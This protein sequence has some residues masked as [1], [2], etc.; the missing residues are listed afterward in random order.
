M[1][2][3]LSAFTIFL[4]TAI[5]Y[6]Q[7]YSYQA[8]NTQ[9]VRK[10][11]GVIASD[12]EGNTII[13]GYFATSITFGSFTLTNNNGY[14]QAFVAKKLPDG[15]FAWAKMFTPLAITGG[16]SFS[17][18]HGVCTDATGNVYVTGRFSG[19]ISFGGNISLSSTKNGTTY[20]G[21]IFTL[22]MSPAGTVLWAKSVG[23]AN[24]GC[25]AGE[26]GNSVA[27]DNSGNVYATGQIVFKVFKNT[28][29]C[30][31]IVQ[32]GPS[33]TNATSK[34]ITCPY[35]VKYNAA[36]TK[37]WEKKYGNNGALAGTSCW[38]NHPRG[39]D[40]GTDGSNIYVTGYFYGNVDFGN[41]FLNTGS[42]TVSNTFLI[43]LNESGSSIWSRSVTGS[44]NSTYG[45][46]GLG[47][48]LFV[49]GNDLY[50]GGLY[51]GNISFGTCSLPSSSP[52]TFLAKY[53]SSGT[54]QWA[55]PLG[56]TSY[57][58]VRHPNGNLAMLQRGRF[59]S[60]MELSP[61]D[62]TIIDSTVTPLEDTAT[63]SAGGYPSLT[64]L[65]DGFIFS[66]MVTGTYHFGELTITASVPLGGGWADMMLIQYTSSTPPSASKGSSTKEILRTGIVLY[67]N[68][69]TNQVTVKNRYSK[70]LGWV[71]IYDGSGK[72]IY[73]SLI[74][75]SFAI[76]DL[77]NFTSGVYYM[78]SD[79]IETAIKFLKH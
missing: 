47:D 3:L 25:N 23:T 22:K 42:E 44:A 75:S 9:Q 60:I 56:G 34:S 68:P 5:G 74:A 13:T 57:G 17:S 4:I 26:S 8:I 45:G 59:Y 63:G 14:D 62:G 55:I 35:V 43:K 49:D 28:T 21:D 51:Y 7:P 38:S 77:K 33:C 41:G 40:I 29:I 73:R 39:T 71:Y 37:I 24:D 78:R 70:P 58:V 48:D 10:N 64:S 2:K 15:S 12:N 72:M 30:N 11:L 52:P 53:S 65:P 16:T 1:K 69:A 79:Q 6:S 18:I 76:I 54:C 19:K 66:Q 50:L 31:E 27:V 67:P 61:L 20:T 32:G 36:G 46:G